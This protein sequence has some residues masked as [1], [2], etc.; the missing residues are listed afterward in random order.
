MSPATERVLYRRAQRTERRARFLWSSR[1]ALA[2]K[3]TWLSA[4][5]LQSLIWHHRAS[6]PP[7]HKRAFHAFH[8]P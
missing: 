4:R 1:C 5:I 8:D 3:P 2:C 6:S 7:P